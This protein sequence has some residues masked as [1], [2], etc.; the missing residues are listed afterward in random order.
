MATFYL[1][2]L[3]FNT[4]TEDN[5]R[6]EKLELLSNGE[7]SYYKLSLVFDGKIKPK[8]YSLSWEEDQVD[9]MGFWSSKSHFDKNITPDWYMRNEMSRTATGMPLISIYSKSNL[10]RTTVALSDPSNPSVLMAGCI[11]E[12]G[13]VLFKLDLFPD[14][15][16][17]MSSYEVIIRI[18]RRKMPFYKSV[19]DVK[20][21]WNEI[22][23]K[24][25]YVPDHAKL[26]MYSAWY[27]YHQ[28]IDVDAII[29]ECKQ[30]KEYG[31]DT[32]IVD[33]GW[34]TDDSSRGYAYCGDW[35]VS[36]KKIPDMK[37]FVDE[38]HKIG[39]KF[40]IWFSVP[41]MGVM[42]ENYE[43]FKGMYLGNRS[44]N[45][46]SVLDPRYKEVRDFLCDIYATHVENYGWDGLK[47]DFI[48]SFRPYE[49]STDYDPRMDC[50]SVEEGVIK[51]L[52]E[53]SARLKGANPEFMIEFRQSYVGPIMSMYGNFFRVGDCPCDV[54]VNRIGA[55]NLRLTS[56]E[57][58]V[59]SDMIMWNKN[60]TV[61]SVAYQLLGTLLIVPQIS[62]R[63]D[64]ITDEHK[65]LL[66]GY[67]SFWREH[68][69]TI[70]NGE[71]EI[72][73]AEANYSMAKST[74]DTESVCALY[75]NVVA[76]VE[77]NK[78]NYIF[79]STGKSYAYVES[80]KDCTY[81]LYNIYGEKEGSGTLL[82]GVTKLP[83]A[84]CGMV[85]IF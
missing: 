32:I 80:D 81:E 2:N 30:A 17:L 6:E 50:V 55:I 38:I 36:K 73:D 29:K 76:K 47:L 22:G 13:A 4:Q 35:Q 41:F 70:L 64:D 46:S 63:F 25:C 59:H 12:R 15:S 19:Q 26:P 65:K 14:I 85:K 43:R 1:N 60:D 33:D 48:D 68:R 62:I 56:G 39:M 44:S 16:P 7:I 57:T 78:T 28:E 3:T 23:Y 51:L 66:K 27:S 53:V 72:E 10:N 74:N 84:N 18:D 54:V 71:I 11:E 9:M 52:S 34:Q 8:R 77:E 69:D 82:R 75:Q 40:V 49:S 24:N 58:A 67:L 42:S 37:R 61:E 20:S 79:N 83:V 45:D 5:L 21:W 31:M